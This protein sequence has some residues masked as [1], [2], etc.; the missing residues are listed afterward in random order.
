[1]ALCCLAWGLIILTLAR[2]MGGM[3]LGAEHQMKVQIALFFTMHIS[4]LN[5]RSSL[6]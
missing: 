4:Y 2:V 6:S 3:N 1:M 5:C